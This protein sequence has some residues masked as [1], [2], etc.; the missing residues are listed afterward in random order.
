MSDSGEHRERARADLGPKWVWV[1]TEE[2]VERGAISVLACTEVAVGIGLYWWLI[3]WWLETNLHLLISV[4]VAPLLLLR[5]PASVAAALA[6]FERYKNSKDEGLSLRSKRGAGGGVG[7]G[8]VV[9]VALAGAIPGSGAVTVAVAGVLL[10]PGLL[11]GIWLRSAIV[12]VGSTLR[13]WKQGWRRLPVNW[14]GLV[15]AH[16]LRRPTEL[17]PGIDRYPELS[18]FGIGKL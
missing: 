16:D 7:T 6:A 12:R 17:L 9:G 18:D 15:W 11:L 1:S 8:G 4:L 5:S 13:H 2:S 10:G 14:R 3:P